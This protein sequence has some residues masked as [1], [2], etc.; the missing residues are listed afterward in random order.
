MRSVLACAGVNLHRW[1][2]WLV[3]TLVA[4]VAG[5]AVLACVAGARRTDSAYPQF[6][7]SHL[8][9]DMVVY[10]SFAPGAVRSTF[11]QI[12]HLPQVKVAALLKGYN[13]DG[14]IAVVPTYSYGTAENVP[15]ILSGQLPRSDRPGEVAL[16]YTFA[17]ARHLS[18]GSRLVVRFFGPPPVP[19]RPPQT[20][21]VSMRVVGIEVSPGD[22][23]PA[24]QSTFFP[25]MIMTPAF[26][27]SYGPGLGSPV[28]A[29]VVR[30]NHGDADAAAFESAL[31]RLTGGHPQADARLAKQAE[32]VQRG[33]HLQAQALWFLAGFL[34]VA[35]TLVLYQLLAR[36]SMLAADNHPTLR[37]LGMTR[38]QLWLAGLVLPVAV[39]ATGG[40]MAIALAVAVSPV[41]PVGTAR[42]AEEHPGLA[43][44]WIV[45][46][47]GLVAIAA[48]VTAIAL[49][50]MWRVASGGV[51]ERNLG[52]AGHLLR[53]RVPVGAVSP[54]ASIGVRMALDPGV[55]RSAVPVRS[56]LAGITLSVI[57]LTSALTFGSSLTRLLT[58]PHLYGWNWDAHIS[59]LTA[60]QSSPNT[61]AVLLPKLTSDR[62][63]E[64]V[65]TLGSPPLLVG[66]ASV[67]GVALQDLKGH[68]APVVLTGRAPVSADEVA[69]GAQT[70]RDLHAHIGTI[71]PVSISITQLVR[72]PKRVVGVVVVP[73]ENDAA[74]LGV[75][76]M[77]TNGG[78]QSLIPPGVHASP[79][80]EAVFTL[81]PGSDHA[82][83]LTDVRR[84]LGV[85]WAVTGPAPPTDLVNFG[86]VQELP[87]VLAALLALL[88]MATLAHIV[89]S[90]VSRRSRD[91][92][93][94]KTL[95]FLRVQVRRT[96]HWESVTLVA[97]ALVVGIPL[98][99]VSGRLLW[100]AFAVQLGTRPEPVT[101]LTVLVLVPAALAAAYL[102]AAP[103]ALLATRTRPA[104]VLRSE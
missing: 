55:G 53:E 94:L 45:M 71:V 32:N 28:E 24:L 2:A 75:G 10:Q 36:Q 1:R 29:L 95:G 82:A 83:V 44:D 77:L 72:S 51:A 20:L 67:T 21:P 87:I 4:G 25:Q 33:I 39:G 59:S 101:S 97:L 65:A 104:L 43:A 63:I 18:V 73:P 70:M 79:R 76:A 80:S 96:V 47:L 49:W 102:V 17:N 84:E 69:L 3:L 46:G 38:T 78:I 61:L 23:P 58:T 86:H 7:R 52:R 19:G 22:F 56:S 99:I 15:K 54:A 27:S 74:R 48:V 9:A 88:A 64:A 34:A 14:P 68:T 92:A 62:R 85:Q 57:A 93:V 37:A 8:A 5:G 11:G 66:N 31:R 42:I 89:F 91:L 30:L 16:T 41:L 40:A 6:A 100:H 50:P 26:L 103:L 13:T 98:G 81:S 90:S 60:A 12:A 35:V